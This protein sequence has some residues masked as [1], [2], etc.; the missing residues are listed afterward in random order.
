MERFRSA[1]GVVY[2]PE[3]L[4]GIRDVRGA[5]RNALEHPTRNRCGALLFA[6]MKLTIAFDDISLTLPP[7]RKPDLRQVIIEEVLRLAAAAGVD[8]VQ[9]V[10]ANALHRRMTADELRDCNPS[11]EAENGGKKNS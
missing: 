7:M 10:A 5:V 8:D 3:S 2:P 4:A 11:T 1:P 9:I 6:R